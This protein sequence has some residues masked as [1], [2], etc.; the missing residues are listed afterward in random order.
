MLRR[1]FAD[2]EHWMEL[3]KGRTIRLPLWGT[4]CTTRRMTAWLKRIGKSVAWYREYTGMRTL[5]DWIDA[6]PLYPMR[7]FAGIMLEAAEEH[8][9]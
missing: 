1:N 5:Q 7:A 6:N 4:P 9:F 8:W 3:A 2:D